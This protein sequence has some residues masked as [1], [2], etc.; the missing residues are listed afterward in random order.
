MTQVTA[1]EPEAAE[2]EKIWAHSGDSHAMEPDDL[3]T[4]RLPKRLA[5]RA[6]RTERGEKYE[7]V[8]VDGQQ[9][10]RQLNDFMD[11][12]RPP[13]ASDI[14]VRLRDLD[15]EGVQCQLA[16]PSSGFWSVNIDDA[17]AVSRGGPGLERLVAAGS[18]V[19]ADA[20]L[21]SRDRPAGRG[22]GRG[23]RSGMG[24]R[25]KASSRYSCRARCRSNW[26][27]ALTSGAAVGRR[28]CSRRRVGIPHRHG[29]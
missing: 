1:I 26:S 8:Y 10:S 23:G 5:D 11:A 2:R 29:R 24:G 9:L 21:H 6:P 15:Q 17:G 3:W 27:G 28:G 12:I 20:Y 13:G 19:V 14:A 16:F 4:S 22:G 25:D 7:I 18:H